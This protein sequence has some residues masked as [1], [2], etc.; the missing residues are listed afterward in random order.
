MIDRFLQF[1]RSHLSQLLLA[2]IFVAVVVALIVWSSINSEV[3]NSSL[4]ARRLADMQEIT[5]AL[6][7]YA[8]AHA[9]MYP[10][11][12]DV[13]VINRYLPHQ[14]LDPKTR[15]PYRYFLSGRNLY[16][17]CTVFTDGTDRCLH[18]STTRR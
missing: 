5:R 16:S 9:D 17:V 2:M 14:Y 1:C 3:E 15:Y 8:S 7:L 10:E 12:L 13:L 11:S 18:A 6:D 4:D